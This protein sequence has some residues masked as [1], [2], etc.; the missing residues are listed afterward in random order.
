VRSVANFTRAD[1]REFLALAAEV[2][3][4]VE[5]ETHALRDAN[6]VLGR[7]KRGEVQGAAVLV[8]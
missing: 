8:P 5:V 3:L 7:L 4:G 2:G 6:D 1:A